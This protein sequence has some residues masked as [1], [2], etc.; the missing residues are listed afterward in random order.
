MLPYVI[1]TAANIVVLSFL[2]FIFESKFSVLMVPIIR[3]I[4]GEHFN[5]TDKLLLI[6]K[7][8][9]YIMNYSGLLV[10]IFF[11]GITIAFIKQASR[12]LKPDWR[13][14]VRK[15][16][17]RYLRLL[18]VWGVNLGIYYILILSIETPYQQLLSDRALVLFR[19][20]LIMGMQMVFSLAIPAIIIENRKI[21]ASYRRAVGLMKTYPLTITLFV[22]LPGFLLFPAKYMIITSSVPVGSMLPRILFNILILQVFA[23]TIIDFMTTS[24][25][26]VLLLW[27]RN[28]ERR[29]S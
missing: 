26:A 1:L 8:F 21:M 9:S 7:L 27:H 6:P 23:V 29:K 28:F 11:T 24:S 19:F 14:G 25:A 16:L 4:W 22:L 2:F 3:I 5:F 12:N 15:T 17:K 10:G 20:I 13:F 18:A